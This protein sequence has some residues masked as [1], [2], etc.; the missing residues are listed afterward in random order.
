MRERVDHLGA[1]A[2]ANQE[3]TRQ[4]LVE[5]RKRTNKLSDR[6]GTSTPLIIW[7]I[8]VL[9]AIAYLYCKAY[10]PGTP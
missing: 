3:W 2:G 9:V 8:A 1:M 10:V 6:L 7:N 4:Q 5:V